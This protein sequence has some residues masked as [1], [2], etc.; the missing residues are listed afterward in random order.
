MNALVEDQL[1]EFGRHLT[2]ERGARS[3]TCG[4]G[5]NRI[6]FGRYTSETP[7]TGHDIHPRLDPDDQ[8]GARQRRLTRLFERVSEMDLTQLRVRQ[9]V[10]NGELGA[11]GRFLF[12]SIDGAELATRWD[13]QAS[14][15]DILISN[16]SMLGAML[17]REV[18]QPIFE[19]DTWLCAAQATKQGSTS[20][21]MNSTSTRLH[22]E[23]RWLIHPLI[24]QS[25][26]AHAGGASSQVGR[27]RLIS[28]P[29]NRRPE[30]PAISR[31]PVGYVRI[32]RHSCDGDSD[33]WACCVDGTIVPGRALNDANAVGQLSPEKF[34]TFSNRIG[35][36]ERESLDA[37]DQL[38]EDVVVELL[39]DLSA[40]SIFPSIV[41]LSQLWPT[42]PRLQ[43]TD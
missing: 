27:A 28:I 16:I 15:P 26:G 8:V 42:R 10:G 6:F 31:L 23:R 9:M 24:A 11:S 39:K 30:G 40:D 22:P 17:N 3:S 35:I 21:W 2:A 1:R 43:L 7:V 41:R 13:I 34:Q 36:P 38:S 20:S 14:A 25:T 19:A 32:Q 4:T 37:N 18:D 12:P 5:A 33:G 29:P